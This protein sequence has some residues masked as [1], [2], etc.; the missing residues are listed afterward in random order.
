MIPPWR[1][2]LAVFSSHLAGKLPQEGWCVYKQKDI[3]RIPEWSRLMLDVLFLRKKHLHILRMPFYPTGIK[4]I[5]GFLIHTHDG[6]F[7]H[8]W[9]Y[10]GG[11]GS[12]PTK[13]S[14]HPS[15]FVWKALTQTSNP[16]RS[17]LSG[18]TCTPPEFFL[19]LLLNEN[20]P[21]PPTLICG[22]QLH[23]ANSSDY[24]SLTFQWRKQNSKS[25]FDFFK[26]CF[27]FWGAGKAANEEKG[28]GMGGGKKGVSVFSLLASSCILSAHLQCIKK[29]IKNQREVDLWQ[30]LVEAICHRTTII[31]RRQG[32]YRGIFI[33]TK[34]RWIFPDNYQAWGE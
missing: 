20:P 33:E 17:S 14:L 31:F 25:I 27:L 22:Q 10:G 30:V 21:L 11:G 28:L 8:G 16:C 5:W 4:S 29:C 1:S 23:F 34:S 9:I 32:D 6:G 2:H 19:P 7:P 12:N 24:Q 13:I 18:A 15:Y 3:T 26:V